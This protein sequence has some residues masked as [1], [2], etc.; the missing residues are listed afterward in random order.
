MLS[1][2]KAYSHF[3]YKNSIQTD[4]SS[5][6]VAH[7]SVILLFVLGYTTSMAGSN[8]EMLDKWQNTVCL[9]GSVSAGR[10]V[11]FWRNTYLFSNRQRTGKK[12]LLRLL[13]PFLWFIMATWNIGLA[14]SHLRHF[15]A[16][17]VFSRR[18]AKLFS[19]AL[20][21]T[22]FPS[23]NISSPNTY[24]M[25]SKKK[26]LLVW[27]VLSSAFNDQ[28]ERQSCWFYCVL[29]REMKAWNAGRYLLSPLLA[30]WLTKAERSLA[31]VWGRAV[32]PGHPR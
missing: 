11:H 24:C 25:M 5:Y 3:L 31:R 18:Q 29:Q 21:T 10:G 7:V 1:R 8:T 27:N 4:T 13:I 20:S 22:H 32:E 19:L 2:L 16:G 14:L 15:T 17:A 12:S 28:W 23:K 30:L 26:L 9:C 6:A